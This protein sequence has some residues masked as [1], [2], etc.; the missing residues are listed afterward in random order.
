MT[1][2]NATGRAQSDVLGFVFVFAIVVATIGLV[3]T[4]GFSGLQDARDVERVNNAERAFEVFQNNVEDM[5][6][7]GAPSR[8][9]EIKLAGASLGFGEPVTL[10]V[11]EAGGS[12][13]T[14]QEIEPIVYDADTGTR[15]VYAGGAILRAQAG[16]EI[17]T[18]PPEFVL[19]ADRTVVPIVK[20]RAEESGGIGGDTTVLVRTDVA[21]RNVLYANEGDPVTLWMNLTTPRAEAWHDYLDADDDVA[22]E[23]VASGTVACRVTTRRA[24]VTRIT[25]DAELT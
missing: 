13:N 15:I 23:P 16:G 25:I 11:S 22:C 21:Q 18:H 17:I 9:T 10:N 24:Y 8:A 5:I 1:G 2:A 7:R 3:F 4:A 20:T 19:S 6:D 12:F 14:S